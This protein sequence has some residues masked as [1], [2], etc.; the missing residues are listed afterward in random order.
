MGV[1]FKSFLLV[2][3]FL[4][5]GG[6][7]QALALTQWEVAV[8][9]MGA[10]ENADYQKDID[11]NIIELSKTHPNDYYRLSIYR[12]LPSHDVEYFVDLKSKKLNA[13]DSLFATKPGVSVQVPGEMHVR[14]RTQ[15]SNLLLE[16]VRLG[17]FLDK[18]FQVPLAK[19]I[20][21]IYGHGYGFDGLGNGVS[22]SKLKTNLERFLPERPG[23][24]LDILW[25]DACFMANIEAAYELRGLSRFLVASE[26]AE[27]S[28][29]AP[30]DMLHSLSWGPQYPYRVAID[31]AERFIES[32]SYIKKGAQK[33]SAF[34]SSATISV[35][36]LRR[37]EKLS[38]ALKEL[39]MAL[40]PFSLIQRKELKASLQTLTMD[41]SNLVDLGSMVVAMSKLASFQTG[42]IPEIVARIRVLLDL[43]K[44]EKFQTNPRLL[45]QPNQAKDPIVFGYEDWKKGYRGDRD[46]LERIPEV[47]GESISDFTPGPE[48]K[49]WPYRPLQDVLYFS[50]F[51][52]DLNLFHYY[53]AKDK[54][55]E[56]VSAKAAFKRTKDFVY[57]PSESQTNPILFT[58]YTQ[59]IGQ[60]AE[61]YSGLSIL[62]PTVGLPSFAYPDLEFSLYTGWGSF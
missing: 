28:A 13:W 50:P 43:Q 57:F 18:A 61:R 15:D 36:D 30:F 41:N 55:G 7:S 44:P 60:N 8:L 35:L 37:F 25:L 21:I 38:V 23:H 56:P 1:R 58:G 3:I 12:E 51:S 10:H 19:R 32:Y 42:K 9:F 6:A 16:P 29:G 5:W 52:V 59:G 62:D 40:R 17:K 2:V 46:T 33:G 47:L 34:K 27:F 22:L 31:L 39:S 4:G 53:F 24:P 54:T 48:G 45:I 49:E 20:L 26:E 14:T 11:R